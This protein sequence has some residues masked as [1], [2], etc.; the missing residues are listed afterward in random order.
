MDMPDIQL[1]FLVPDWFQ[2]PLLVCGLSYVV[3]NRYNAIGVACA[4]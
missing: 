4:P 2:G 1:Q 3:P